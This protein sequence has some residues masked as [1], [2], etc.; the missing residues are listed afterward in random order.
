MGT[1]YE[2]GTFVVVPNKNV[3]KGLSPNLQIIFFWVCSFADE[4]GVCWP[5][6]S[7]IAKNSGI[8]K[9]TVDKHIKNLVELG[10]LTKEKRKDGAKNMT[11][12]YQIMVIDGVVQPL[13]QYNRQATLVQ[14][15]TQGSTIDSLGVA[16]VDIQE[17]NTYNS[18]TELNQSNS[19]LFEE[20]YHEYPSKKAKKVAEASWLRVN[21]STGLA[22]TIIEDVK[23]RRVEDKQWLGGFIPM[24]ATYLNQERW[25]DDITPV[26]QTRLPSVPGETYSPQKFRN[27]EKV[28]NIKI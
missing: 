12:V 24:P 25:N 7:T 13:T 14:P 18:T 11:N 28:K 3:L 8:G 16:C 17:L 5:S 21:P 26:N 4:N 15:L 27:I 6:R 1:K 19:S 20:F 9:Q 10:F 22:R 23:K 2:K